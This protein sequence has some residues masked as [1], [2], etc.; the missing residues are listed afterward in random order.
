REG[1]RTLAD[2]VHCPVRK[3]T[4]SHGIWGG[5]ESNDFSHAGCG[6]RPSCAGGATV[7]IKWI[8]AFLLVFVGL[9]EGAGAQDRWTRIN[10]VTAS[11]GTKQVLV[12]ASGWSRGCKGIRIAVRDGTIAIEHISIVYATGRV[13][14]ENV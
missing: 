1:A 11:V 9:S 2:A 10:S 7:M 5:F 13:H 4:Q 3:L 14:A 12:D 8:L 6:G